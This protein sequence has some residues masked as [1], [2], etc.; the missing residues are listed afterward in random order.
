MRHRTTLVIALTGVLLGLGI[1]ASK[2]ISF[3][4]LQSPSRSPASAVAMNSNWK[5]LP[6]GKHLA[7]IKTELTQPEFIPEEGQDEVT[8]NGR[9]YINQSIADGISYT[10]NL[11]DGVEIVRGNL[12][13]T[14]EDAKM[15]EA[16]EVSISVRGFNKEKQ[17]LIFLKASGKHGGEILGNSSTIASRP[18]DTWEAVAPEMKKAAE[19][20][21]EE[22]GT[23]A[24][25][26]VSL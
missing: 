11:P 20:Q 2:V 21:L 18:E 19:E 5:P 13:N 16:I 24:G 15:G 4:S 26:E 22:V 14:I 10:W 8:L 25:S 17:R 1:G 12:R 3:N 23:S 6:L 7:L 9:I